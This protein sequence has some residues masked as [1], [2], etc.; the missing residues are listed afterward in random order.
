MLLRTV[1]FL[2]EGNLCQQRDS[3]G[4]THGLH[5]AK[6]SDGKS[7]LH[8]QLQHLSEHEHEHGLDRDAGRPLE[9]SVRGLI[10]E[11]GARA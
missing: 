3:E 4:C 11:D 10:V 9:R 1:D 2:R 8:M 5:A 6:L 7:R